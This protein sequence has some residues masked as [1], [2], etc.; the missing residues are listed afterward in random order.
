MVL[1]PDVDP[2]GH[3]EARIPL[4]VLGQRVILKNRLFLCM[5]KKRSTIFIAYYVCAVLLRGAFLDHLRVE[6]FA[7]P[8][9]QWPELAARCLV[10]AL[11]LLQHL[12]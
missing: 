4:L 8:F 7:C 10:F 9:G 3:A 2:V 1:L 6:A 12:P 11:Q 5:T